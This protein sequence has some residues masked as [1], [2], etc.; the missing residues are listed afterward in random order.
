[1]Q[2]FIIELFSG[3]P[4][5][6]ATFFIS[7]IP[8]T[9]LRASI[10][11]AI[12]RWELDP[13]RVLFFAVTGNALMGAMVILVLKPV[14]YLIINRIDFLNRFWNLYINRIKTKNVEKFEK[15]GSIALI[16]FVA[17]PLPMTGAFTGAVAA[18]LF[19]IPFKKAVPLIFAGCLI[20]GVIVTAITLLF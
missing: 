11:V 12:L 7:M 19:Q 2:E 3:F 4:K 17:I 9:E 14:T 20:A 16:S 13:L 5:E 8:V 15:W 1:M 18:S 10:P 6:L